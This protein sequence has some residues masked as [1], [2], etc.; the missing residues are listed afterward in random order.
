MPSHSYLKD[1]DLAWHTCSKDFSK[2]Y[3]LTF[4]YIFLTSISFKFA[5]LSKLSI[6]FFVISSIVLN[7]NQNYY[8]YYLIIYFVFSG[9]KKVFLFS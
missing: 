9:H 6:Y 8:Y 5:L 2:M 7:Q 1:F 3:A 4:G